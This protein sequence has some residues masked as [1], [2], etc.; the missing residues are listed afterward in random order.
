VKSHVCK[1]GGAF[2]DWNDALIVD[3][4]YEPFCYLEL[5][6]KEKIHD[7]SLGSAKI[8]LDEISDNRQMSR[9]YDIYD[10]DEI[11]GQILIESTFRQE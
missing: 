6:D 3:R 2:P 11:L 5:K 8:D 4:G 7:M 10:K 1:S 9:W